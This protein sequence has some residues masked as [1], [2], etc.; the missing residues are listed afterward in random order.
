MNRL[1]VSA[2]LL[3]LTCP[4]AAQTPQKKFMAAPVTIEDQ[5]SFF[6]GGITKV[7]DYAAVPFAPPGQTA[8]AP[9]PPPS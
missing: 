6:I 4:M 3:A 5:G 8:P 9:V 2:L 7:S 1:L